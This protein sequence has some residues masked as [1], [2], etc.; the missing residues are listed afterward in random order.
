MN[1]QQQAPGIGHNRQ[2]AAYDPIVE[3]LAGMNRDLTFDYATKEGDATARSYIHVLRGLKGDLDRL[4]KAEKEE[5][6]ARGKLIDGEARAIRD[7]IDANIEKHDAPLREIAVK[8]QARIDIHRST[9]AHIAGFGD[10]ALA[11]REQGAELTVEHMKEWV[12]AAAAQADEGRFEEFAEEV[13]AVT[14]ATILKVENA[15]EQKQA[16]DTEQAELVKLRQ[17][18]QERDAEDQRRRDD[19]REQAR[20][21][22]E[23]RADL[24]R[25][26]DKK[27][28]ELAD[29]RAKR[30][31]A[32]A[33]REKAERE[34]AEAETRE[35]NARIEERARHDREERERK[36][37]DERDR[38]TREADTIH[39]GG[40][41]KEALD[42]FV[43]GGLSA[44]AAKKAVVLIA[45][46]SIPAV[47]IEY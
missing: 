1:D 16:H 4:R 9:I 21:A 28:R 26:A 42:A 14:T 43:E 11:W 22:E 19:E 30:A 32:D 10:A 31:E 17:E 34:K 41:N 45:S 40:I 18:R 2:I 20:V 47:T 23:E 29:E 46:G 36:E 8:E 37:K 33:N 15:I 7:T 38:E 35:A 6:L 13:K 24:K 3:K 44:S 12:A 5:S 39:R 27:D 25:E